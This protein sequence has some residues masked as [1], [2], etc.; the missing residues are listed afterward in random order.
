MLNHLTCAPVNLANNFKHSTV[1][2][3]VSEGGS[4]AKEGPK[5]HK[6]NAQGGSLK[7]ANRRAFLS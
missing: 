6:G 7:I 3:V 2:T 5:N 4:S 1:P